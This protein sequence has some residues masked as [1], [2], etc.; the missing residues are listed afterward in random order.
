MS[1]YTK[2]LKLADADVNEKHLE[3]LKF[4]NSDVALV[5]CYI[6]P[7][8][9]FH[10][11]VEKIKSFF[12]NSVSVVANTTAG[13]LC[14]FNLNQKQDSL[15]LSSEDNWQSVVLQSFSSDMLKSVEIFSM[16]L[17]TNDLEHVSHN[18]IL[19]QRVNYLTDELKKIDIKTNI[20]Y[21]DTL[22][23]TLIDGFSLSENYFLNAV[24]KSGKLP[25]QVIGGSV[26]GRADIKKAYIYND[27]EVVEDTAVVILIKLRQNVK[28]GILKSQNFKRLDISFE[29][30]DADI[31]DR[32][33]ESVIDK[34]LNASVNIIDYLCNIFECSEN[35]LEEKFSM[36]AFGIVINGEDYIR[37]VSSIDLKNRRVNFYCDVGYGDE[38]FLFKTNDFVEQTTK[39]YENFLENKPTKPFAGLLNDCIL[40]RVINA[41]DLNKLK[42]FNDVPLMGFSTFGELLGVNINQT[43]TAVFFFEVSIFDKFRDEFM[44]D[45]VNNYANFRMFY[46]ERAFKSLK[47]RKLKDNYIALNAAKDKLSHYTKKIT[48]LLDNSNQGFLLFN[49]NMLVNDGCSKECSNLL[50]GDKTGQDISIILFPDNVQTQD[51]FRNIVNDV[52]NEKEEIIQQSL[53][54]LLPSIVSLNDK[55]IKIEYKILENREFMLILTNATTQI[56]LERRVKK[57][58]EVLKMIVSI[59]SD[60][61]AFY[62]TKRDYDKFTSQKLKFVSEDKPALYNLNKLYRII[63]TFK[64]A[65][66]QFYMQRTVEYLHKVESDLSTLMK[67]DNIT[68]ID[69][70]DFLKK[71]RFKSFTK[72]DMKTVQNMLEETFFNDENYINVNIEYVEQIKEKVSNYMQNS[73][74]KHLVC[75]DI[76]CDIDKLTT[77]KVINTLTS[78]VTMSNQLA[79]RLDKEIFEIEIEGDRELALPNE[80]FKPFMKSLLHVFRNCVAHG[81]E[82]ADTRLMHNKDE[83]G[84]I[85]CSFEED[86]EFLYIYIADDGAGINIEK[87][88]TK[89]IDKEID[90]SNLSKQDLYKY[91]F[92]N[93]FSTS[94]EISEISG[95]GY[96]MSAVKMELERLNGEYII[97]SEL[98]KGTKFTFKLPILQGEI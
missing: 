39:D 10:E 74:P 1:K 73:T 53:F 54:S 67:N 38:L 14:T 62:D 30:V 22:A 76:L 65:F 35:D 36:Y 58:Q 24:Y 8:L 51:L 84:R 59:V 46:K 64:G 3:K 19:E 77:T 94:D 49:R 78:Y 85:T 37:S 98:T 12:G 13:E 79:Q 88:K 41:G 25:C 55:E 40:R 20:D 48:T 97:D 21:K 70:V 6:S 34:D 32:Y 61:S 66:L 2:V 45:F 15:Y 27:S 95:R 71:I 9:N 7:Y 60:K 43:L 81:I 83:K 89:L 63:H 29:V 75:E 91:I 92:E 47:S 72:H 50:E 44:D 82:D 57:E 68:N 86:D 93:S 69:I 80:D 31:V 4:K 56:E 52:Y 5:L 90:I 23:L 18:K 42:C 16:D 28:F 33:I 17:K 87:I 26:S 11:I 96:G